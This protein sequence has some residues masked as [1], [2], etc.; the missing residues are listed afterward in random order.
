MRWLLIGLFISCGPAFGEDS[1]QTYA[2]QCQAMVGTIPDFSCADGAVV[3]VTIGGVEPAKFTKDMLCDRPALLSNGDQSDGQCVPYSR[4]LNLSAGSKQIS[5]MCRQK[6]IRE[7]DS[8]LYDEI[9]VI[10][11]N[12]STGATCWFQANAGTDP[13]DGALVPSPQSSEAGEFWEEPAVV[14]GDGCGNCHDNDPFMYSPFVGQVWDHV[15][16]NPFGP[17][18]HVAPQFGFAKWPTMAMAPRDSTCTGCHRIGIDK[19]CGY[20]TQLATGEEIPE[21]SDESAASYPAS[22]FMPPD[23]G[24]NQLAW[25]EIHKSSVDDIQGCCGDAGHASCNIHPINGVNE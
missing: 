22:H 16:T 5:V 6:K 14:A 17:Y 7:A 1:R 4:I 20:L 8:L 2:A 19:T 3:P 13:V 10:A 11:H 9:D 21:G 24:L 23:H 12:A 18:F 15:P 25:N